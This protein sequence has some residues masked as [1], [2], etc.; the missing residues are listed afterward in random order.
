[1]GISVNGAEL[2]AGSA[3][4]PAER[5]VV[6]VLSMFENKVREAAREYSPA[7]VANY[8]YELAKEYNQF[9]QS[10]PIFSETDQH[11]LKLRVALSKCVADAIRRSMALLGIQVPEK[12]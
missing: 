2:N 3:L 11:K 9:Y 12:M 1:M 8:A 6:Q 10:I 4:E 5:E 7:I